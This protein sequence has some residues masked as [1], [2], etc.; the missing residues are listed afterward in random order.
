M[1]THEY[2]N[3]I[4]LFSCLC[5]V[6]FKAGQ[7]VNTFVTSIHGQEMSGLQRN[8]E[9]ESNEYSYM[10]QASNDDNTSQNPYLNV[11][12]QSV[13]VEVV[14]KCMVRPRNSSAEN[15]PKVATAVDCRQEDTA[16]DR[17][18]ANSKLQTF[19]VF[20]IGA[21]RGG[22]QYVSLTGEGNRK[23]SLGEDCERLNQQMD[24]LI[25]YIFPPKYW[26]SVSQKHVKKWIRSRE[27]LYS[28]LRNL[29]VNPGEV[30]PK[31]FCAKNIA[32]VMIIFWGHGTYELGT[33]IGS[34]VFNDGTSMELRE[35]N[36][37]IKNGWLKSTEHPCNVYIWFTQ[38]YGHKFD[39]KIQFEGPGS[40]YSFRVFGTTC[41]KEPKSH[42]VRKSNGS[43]VLWRDEKR[44]NKAYVV[45]EGLRTF[46]ATQI[47]PLSMMAH[48]EGIGTGDYQAADTLQLPQ[49]I[50]VD[51][52]ESYLHMIIVNACKP[53]YAYVPDTAIDAEYEPEDGIS[54]EPK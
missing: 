51:E 37:L 42:T 45:I 20:S 16:T 54:N 11:R 36:K 49:Y 39:G 46:I 4:H 1:F 24:E 27:E 38:C 41:D 6:M 19:Q 30:C 50:D 8:F 33:R 13:N 29:S 43:Y 52:L 40:R 31:N 35:I 34:L 10:Q 28:Y 3:A 14:K 9:L 22:V 32:T 12:A 25:R 47:D 7:N 26:P 18:Y 21:P 48:G 2:C 44:G 5:C 53:T 15:D 23:L 17:A